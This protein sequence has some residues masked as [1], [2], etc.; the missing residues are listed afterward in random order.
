MTMDWKFAAR[1]SITRCLDLAAGM[2][3]EWKMQSGR[4]KKF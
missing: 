1:S 2:A 4:G 3:A